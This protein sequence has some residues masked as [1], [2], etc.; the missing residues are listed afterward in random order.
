MDSESRLNQVGLVVAMRFSAKDLDA[1]AAVLKASSV[2]ESRCG[3]QITREAAVNVDFGG[4]AYVHFAVGN[5]G[6]R[7]L[8]GVPGGITRFCSLL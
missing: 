4:S 2:L 8:Y 6:N 3:S 1:L 7:E 5:R